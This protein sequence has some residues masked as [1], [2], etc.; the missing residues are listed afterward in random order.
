MDNNDNIAKLF[1]DQA[2]SIA[3]MFCNPPQQKT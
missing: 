2:C 1:N 3:I